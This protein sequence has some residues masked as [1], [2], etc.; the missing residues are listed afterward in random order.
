MRPRLG[1]RLGL[2]VAAASLASLGL[3]GCVIGAG[4]AGAFGLVPTTY[5]GSP[6]HAT[7]TV[8]ELSPTTGT[9]RF[10]GDLDGFLTAPSTQAPEQVALGYVRQHAG[11]LGLVAGDL[12]T[13]HLERDYRDIEGIHHLYF[14]QRV[15]GRQLA[16]QGLTAA[17]DA[18]GRLLVLGGMPASSTSGEPH[19]SGSTSVAPH[20]EHATGRAYRMFPGAARG[21][22]QVHVDFTRRGWL[23]EH[24]TTLSGNNAHA[25]SDVDDNDRASPSEEVHPLRGH[26]WGYR[27]HPAF[28][29]VASD[30][31][32]NP[33]PCSWVPGRAGSWRVNRAQTT[34]QAFFFVNTWHDHLLRAPIGFTEAAGNFQRHNS[35]GEGKGGDPVIVQTDDGADSGHGRLAGLPDSS[36][37][38]DSNMSTPPDGESPTMQ[39]YLQHR[40][41][42]SYP[43]GDPWSPTNSGDEADTVYH[44]YTHGL[45]SRLVV[46]VR[47]HETLGPVQGDSMGEAWSDWYALDYLVDQGLDS[48]KPGRADVR[49]SVYD[50]AGA[51][52]DRTEPIDCGVDQVDPRLDPLCKGGK[53]G[54]R[55]GYTYADYGHVVSGDPRC[56]PTVRSG[57][58]PCGT[59]G[60][61][62]A[63]GGRRSLVT[64]AMELAPYDPSFLDMRNAILL[65]D[66]AVYDG[67]DRAAIW[68]V[69]AQRGMGFYAGSLTGSDSRPAAS[70]ALPPGSSATG[71]IEG[72]V[73]D[74]ETGQPLA[75]MH[76]TLAFQ[77]S[78]TANPTVVT[79]ADGHYAITGVPHGHYGKLVVRGRHHEDRRKQVTVVSGRTTLDFTTPRS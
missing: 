7:R 60:A 54:H 23:G 75:G 34:T 27:L 53:T 18:K 6:V 51:N 56:T 3:A 71:S 39:L 74:A 38:D 63:R 79:D 62:S 29:S 26:F 68:E 66:T 8:L 35:T 78:G 46:D 64:R 50:G 11:M 45:S 22:R 47:G 69:F 57:V 76:V 61:G 28:P 17:V 9:V 48:D 12:A 44:E 73:A 72:T 65:A 21:G 40:P 70:F 42:T 33:W 25:Y 67:S 16:H 37:V 2:A 58:R 1:R 20:F 36:H 77:G 59:S 24:A 55:G 30:F 15:D 49:L 5:A 43:H 32:G 41:F 14:T 13:F 52:E 19:L 31:C 10:L 4:G